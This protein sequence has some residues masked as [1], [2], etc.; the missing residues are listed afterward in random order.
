LSD[1]PFA[2]L[3]ALLDDDLIA[4]ALAQ[5]YLALIDSQILF[6]DINIRTLC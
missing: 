6:D 1:D 5:S 4:L 2:R 3:N